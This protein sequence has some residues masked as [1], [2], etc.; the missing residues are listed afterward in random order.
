MLTFNLAAA[1][2]LQALAASATECSPPGLSLGTATAWRRN[3]A[4]VASTY[5]APG[6][7]PRPRSGLGVV[8]GWA[9]G[10]VWVAI[11]AHVLYGEGAKDGDRQK[12]RTGLAIRLAGDGDKEA[13]P[14]CSGIPSEKNPTPRAAP[15]DVAFACVDGKTLPYLHAGLRGRVVK[16]GDAIHL[17]TPTMAKEV[18][19]TILELGSR[20][21]RGG[22]VV[23]DGLHGEKGMS[24]ALT[25]NQAGGVGLYLAARG[26][27]HFGAA[28]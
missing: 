25:V 7:D 10:K 2:L 28:A 27:R 24:G 9:E 26:E 15:Y 20:I 6:Q 16:K 21:D 1:G 22:D 8:V 4:I 17:E 13:R 5:S 19:G 3:V 11:P 18:M 12:Y 14:L 23:A